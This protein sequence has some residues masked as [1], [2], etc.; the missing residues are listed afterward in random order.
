MMLLDRTLVLYVVCLLAL[1]QLVS[2]LTLQLD[3]PASVVVGQTFV[4][5]GQI[6]G[7]PELGEFSPESIREFDLALD[8]GSLLSFAGVQI[9]PLLGTGASLLS[10]VSTSSGVAQV[11]AVS[12]LSAASLDG[13]QPRDF[14]LLSFELVAEQVGTADLSLTRHDVGD[15]AGTPLATDALGLSISIVPEPALGLMGALGL[16]RFALRPYG[17]RSD[18]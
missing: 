7:A 3:G 5:S 13:L 10:E 18:R 15:T 1:P 11:R 2:A 12:L 17:V 9:S 14:P 4:V 8:H 16:L 6:S